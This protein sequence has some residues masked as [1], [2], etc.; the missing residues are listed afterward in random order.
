M[1]WIVCKWSCDGIRVV[2]SRVFEKSSS[3]GS[4]R[5]VRRKVRLVIVDVRGVHVRLIIVGSMST[6]V[7]G[8]CCRMALARV[9]FIANQ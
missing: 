3:G 1:H 7:P 4:V 2:S 9:V 6:S 5:T 8:E